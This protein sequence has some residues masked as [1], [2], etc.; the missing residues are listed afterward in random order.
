MNP[1]TDLLF[2][3]LIVVYIVDLSGWTDTWLGWLSRWLGH[4]VRELKP[5]SCSLC[6]TWWAG[7]V[8]LLC[9]GRFCLPLI[10]YVAGL[11]FLSF[12]LTQILI[13]TREIL[14]KWINKIS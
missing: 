3:S 2:L 8:Y 11:S 7:I 1:W 12:P 10:A 5:F 6:M 13:F 9:T 4:P 14:M